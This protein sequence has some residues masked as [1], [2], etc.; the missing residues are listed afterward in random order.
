MASVCS[1]LSPRRWHTGVD[2]E[3]DVDPAPRG[4]AQRAGIV[5]ADGALGELI[6]ADDAPLVDGRIAEDKYQAP[7]AGPAEL[8]ALGKAGDREGTDADAV[9]LPRRA[10]GPVA[11]G[12]A[13]QDRHELAALR[14]EI[15]KALCVVLERVEADLNPGAAVGETLRGPILAQ[16]SSITALAAAEPRQT[17]A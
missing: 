3:V 12:V 15:L 5:R 6:A 4:F 7:H 8:H 10:D 16:T 2:L 17:A 1:Q 14:R 9:E 13:L 11:V